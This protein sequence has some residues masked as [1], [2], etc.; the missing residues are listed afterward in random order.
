[1]R[2]TLIAAMATALVAAFASPGHASATAPVAIWELNEPAGSTVVTDTGPY[3]L[4]GTVGTEVVTGAA[5]D[6]ATTGYD[7][8]WLR[9][10]TPPAH[11]QT[12]VT[13]PDNPQL[14]PGARE[15]AVTLRMR[16]TSNFGNVI[17]K[18]QGG[19]AGGRWKIEVPKG[20]VNCAFQ[21]SSGYVEVR[22]P[23]F[24]NDG[25][26]HVV[27]CERLVKSVVLSIDGVVVGTTK[28]ATGTIA[29][30]WPVSIGGKTSCDQI[31][32]TCDYFPGEIDRVQIDA[33]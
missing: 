1:M 11:P 21:G 17:Q 16:T 22:S 14:N 32:V 5:F 27:K 12:L 18:G 33:S 2:P 4:T 29:N 8:Q 23:G 20:N 9:P 26:W 13:V 24:I 10:N 3:G 31:D 15:Y 28:G 6:A 7:F 25:A 19:T 30:T